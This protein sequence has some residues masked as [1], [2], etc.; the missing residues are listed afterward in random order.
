MKCENKV[1]WIDGKPH[2]IIKLDDK[3]QLMKHSISLDDN[4][5]KADYF[6]QT[7]NVEWI[8]VERKD[9]PVRIERAISQIKS[10]VVQLRSSTNNKQ[11]DDIL[12]VGE[13]IDTREQRM[14]G[15]DKESNEL[16]VKSANLRRV[17]VEGMN[18][19]FYR[20]KEVEEMRARSHDDISRT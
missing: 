9:Q 13:K 11:V 5:S 4:Q 20:I 18:L 8:V 10:T 7:P 3:T 1:P 15:V 17:N 2:E 16:Y 19:K 12:V 6:M 14:Y